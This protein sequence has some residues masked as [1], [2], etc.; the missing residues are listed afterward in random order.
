M[1]VVMENMRMIVIANTFSSVDRIQVS[2]L[3]DKPH[4]FRV[5]LLILFWK[6]RHNYRI[7]WLI[8]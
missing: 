4:I 7:V 2:S 1:T 5:R 6:N 3:W 8:V